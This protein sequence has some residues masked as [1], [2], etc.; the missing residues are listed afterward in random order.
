MRVK[1]GLRLQVS[2]AVTKAVIPT[3]KEN[4]HRQIA[5]TRGE[6]DRLAAAQED[7]RRDVRR[8]EA[9]LQTAQLAVPMQISR[10]IPADGSVEAFDRQVDVT[11]AKVRVHDAALV[12]KEA[13]RRA[14]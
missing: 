11:V 3:Q 6:S 2:E 10:R 1:A 5:F 13:L 12:K 7:M 9:A 8:L 4:F 14:V